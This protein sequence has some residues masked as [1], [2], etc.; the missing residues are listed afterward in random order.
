M[1]D[2]H[3]RSS[4]VTDGIL[5]PKRPR[6]NKGVS[7]RDYERLR[8]RAYAGNAAAS[9]EIFKTSDKPDHDPWAETEEPEDPQ[10]YIEKPKP[11]RAPQS[12]KQ[13]PISLLSSS[14]ALPAL[15]QPKPSTSYNPVFEDWSAALVA[16]GQ[17]ELEAELQRRHAAAKEAEKQALIQRTRAEIPEDDMAYY[18]TEGESAWE[19]FESEYTSDKD[20]SWLKKRRPER[21]TPAERNRVKRR[22]EAEGKAKHEIKAREKEKQAKRIAEIAAQFKAREKQQQKQQQQL[23]TSR[24]PDDDD[25][26][27][28]AAHS[29]DS[30]SSLDE[31]KLRRRNFGPAALPAKPL[32]LVLPDE[33]QDSLRLLRPEGNLLKDRFRNLMVRGKIETRKAI[34]QAKRKRVS[35]SEK[36]TY[37]DFTIRA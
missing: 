13:A 37:K 34:Q 21:K 9:K 35:S 32:E 33:L 25:V 20:P 18:V 30:S 7:A 22:K 27:A 8:Q 16:E 4:N 1:V 19:G 2:T 28:A 14:K 17:R 23:A 10:A 31:N 3:K 36:W 24:R 12:M 5:P 11:I 15:S 6:P 29:S 26:A